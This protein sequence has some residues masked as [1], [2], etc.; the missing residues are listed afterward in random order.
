MNL[1]YDEIVC[2]LKLFARNY[3]QAH[4][5]FS[6][7]KSFKKKVDGP[8]ECQLTFDEIDEKNY[9]FIYRPALK[10]IEAFQFENIIKRTAIKRS[11]PL[12][13]CII[14]VW[15]LLN[16]FHLPGISRQVYVKFFE[17]THFAVLN[18][19]AQVDE[20]PNVG[21]IDAEI[22][23]GINEALGFPQFYD[24]IFENIDSYAR[25]TLVNEYCR[26]IIKIH[27]EVKESSWL[28]TQNLHNK[29][30]CEGFKSHMPSWAA[31][32]IKTKSLDVSTHLI[33]SN[34]LTPNIPI[35]ILKKSSKKEHGNDFIENRFR[36]L[37]SAWANRTKSINKTLI[38]IKSPEIKL[39]KTRN[40]SSLWNKTDSTSP[41]AKKV[42]NF[43]D[44]RVIE[45][46]IRDRSTK[47]Q[48]PQQR[49][50]ISPLKYIV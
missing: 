14:G 2:E 32:H 30:N 50:L 6:K 5:S 22:D 29:L 24:S 35:R 31:M 46:I 42:K 43:R 3:S 48:E 38:P 33:R 47:T 26:M 40:L 45:D 34:L 25:S 9:G 1:T 39:R 8:P 10:S 4:N 11:E 20:Y 12:L 37:T 23:F 27:N 36:K 28:K 16:P 44:K 41:I 7:W 19:N 18:I 13:K 17:Y 49:I 15:K 21:K